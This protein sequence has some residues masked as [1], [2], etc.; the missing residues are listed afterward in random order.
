MNTENI[1]AH[2]AKLFQE[3]KESPKY[4]IEGI[5]VEITEK[6]YLTMQREEINNATL[7]KRLGKSRA[8]VSKVLSGKVNF[9]LE[10]LD[11]IAEALGCQLRV[12][13]VPKPSINVFEGL[14]EIPKIRLNVLDFIIPEIDK[15]HC[16]PQRATSARVERNDETISLAA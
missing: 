12:E 15:V 10:T 13:I 4:R 1:S 5:K 3:M 7:A 9:T 14:Q 2:F 8:Y 11:S 16:D 6:I